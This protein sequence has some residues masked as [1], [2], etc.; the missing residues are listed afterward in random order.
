MKFDMNYAPGDRVWA[1]MDEPV[2]F[3]IDGIQSIRHAPHRVVEAKMQFVKI[4]ASER[5][6]SIEYTLRLN[7]GDCHYGVSPNAIFPDHETATVA[8]HK[9]LSQPEYAWLKKIE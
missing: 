3:E 7:N 4:I 5:G 9:T 8:L 2:P 6:M 1:T